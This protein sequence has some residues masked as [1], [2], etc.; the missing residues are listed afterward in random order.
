MHGLIKNP[1]FVMITFDLI[2]GDAFEEIDGRALKLYLIWRR[3]TWRSATKGKLKDWFAK[4]FL[5]AEGYYGTWAKRLGVSRAT[6]KRDV[7]KLVEQGWVKIGHKSR[8]AD[9]PNVIVLGLWRE[10]Q[11]QRVELYYADALGSEPDDTVSSVKQSSD[12]VSSVKQTVSS[13][14]RSEGETVS[15][16]KLSNIEELL[17]DNNNK[18]SN[19]AASQPPLLPAPSSPDE[20]QQQQ[21]PQRLQDWLDILEKTSNRAAVL[22]GMFETLFPDEQISY[23][24]VGKLAKE[25]GGASVLAEMIWKRSANPKRGSNADYIQGTIA[26]RKQRRKGKGRGSGRKVRSAEEL[27]SQASCHTSQQ[28][29]S[30]QQ[31]EPEPVFDGIPLK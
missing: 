5:C 11:G 12:T 8:A 13:V 27:A 30:F 1:Q 14:K 17:I 26:H 3:Y 25:A 16:V 7:D 10:F 15:P 21:Q 29:M 19:G 28:E 18:A 31:E 9:D 23:G 24:R 4:G 2:E 20:K 6:I 22:K